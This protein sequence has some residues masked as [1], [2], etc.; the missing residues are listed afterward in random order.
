MK[1]LVVS[2]ALA[3]AVGAASAATV[4]S[5][6]YSVVSVQEGDLFT[7]KD[8][9]SDVEVRLYGAD[10]PEQGQPYFDESRAYV[11][12]AIKGKEVALDAVT[13][14]EDGHPV[15]VVRGTEG[16]VLH[17]TM[18]E[19]GLAWWDNINVPENHTLSRLN[20]T[21][22][23]AGA[24]L[25]KDAT[26]LTPWDYR[27]SK[28]LKPVHYLREKKEAP[29]AAAPKEEPKVLKAKG[30]GKSSED[31]AYMKRAEAKTDPGPTTAPAP[32]LGPGALAGLPVDTGDVDVGGLIA[33]H[34]PRIASDA[35]GNPIGF[36]AD[37]ISGIPYAAQLG[38][39]DGDI[40]TSVNG[41]P[42]KSEFDAFGLVQT[43]KDVKQF[44]VTL[45]RNGQPTTL[46]INVP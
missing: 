36:T 9:A 12:G 16:G 20:A 45:L 6:K 32:A 38:F 11:E 23:G 15:V 33:V 7:I 25:F 19:K 2:A 8:G 17:E 41:Y 18:V 5:G 31:P 21:A 22:I 35:A 10:A 28:G 24:G 27:K 30:E 13:A 44:N 46:N 29:V 1:S 34:Q 40:V 14:D 26:A 39:R 42:I 4:A 43:L 37:N 3:A